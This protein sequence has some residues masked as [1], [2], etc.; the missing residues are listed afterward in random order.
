[1]K[2]CL[3]K[4]FSATAAAGAATTAA[5]SSGG[6]ICTRNID[7]SNV[8][9]GDEGSPV[10]LKN[11]DNMEFVGVVSYF[12]DVRPNARCQDGHKVVVTQLGAYSTFLSA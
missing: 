11:G 12:P 1:V 4:N 3:I 2:W 9:H 7:D 8:C 6:I 5:A 10:F